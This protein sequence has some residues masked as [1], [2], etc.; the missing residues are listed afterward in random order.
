MFVGAGCIFRKALKTQ[1]FADTISD[2]LS[3]R[4]CE[5]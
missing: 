5:F 4:L 1:L 3:A 2:S